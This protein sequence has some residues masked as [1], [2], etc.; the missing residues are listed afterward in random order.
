MRQ[1][2]RLFAL[3]LLIMGLSTCSSSPGKGLDY[4]GSYF[5]TL[6]GSPTGTISL[7]V[8]GSDITGT[9]SAEASSRFR[10]QGEAPHSTFTGVRNGREVSISAYINLETDL[11][12]PPVVNWQDMSTTLAFT[13]RFAD[14]GILIGTFFG[15]NPL[16]PNNPFSGGWSVQKTSS[17]SS[18]I[19]GSTP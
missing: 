7:E 3:I 6:Q 10:G 9:I 19:T 1:I 17:V 15:G 13:A 16:Q 5:G 12:E 4:N 11:G 14:S 8:S 18:S 2:F